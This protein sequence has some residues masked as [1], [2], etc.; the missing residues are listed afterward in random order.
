VREEIEPAAATCGRG[1]FVWFVDDVKPVPRR[2]LLG[3]LILLAL[4]EVCTTS[5]AYLTY[6]RVT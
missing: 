4:V 6:G 1:R 3:I 2:A 5:L